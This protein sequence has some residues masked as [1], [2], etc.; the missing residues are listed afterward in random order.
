MTISIDQVNERRS[1]YTDLTEPKN[2]IFGAK[3]IDKI[4]GPRKKKWNKN[5]AMYFL[6]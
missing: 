5:T 6:K 1:R 2:Y 3:L 4:I